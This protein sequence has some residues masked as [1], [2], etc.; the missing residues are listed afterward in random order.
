MWE[1]GSVA[2]SDGGDACFCSGDASWRVCCMLEFSDDSRKTFHTESH[3][4]LATCARKPKALG[5]S[6]AAS[7]V[8]R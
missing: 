8:Q 1:V 6:P 3:S 7:Y 4:W 2:M 5:S